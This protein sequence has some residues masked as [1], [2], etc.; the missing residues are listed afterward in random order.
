MSAKDD[1]C[2]RKTT[3]IVD[4]PESEHVEY[5]LVFDT[6]F[7]KVERKVTTTQRLYG[8]PTQ[9]FLD[10]INPTTNDE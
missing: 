9:A 5:T 1:K 3:M 6:P 8:D 10:W 4:L 7:G 2:G